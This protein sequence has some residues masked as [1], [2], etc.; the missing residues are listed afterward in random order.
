MDFLVDNYSVTDILK[1]MPDTHSEIQKLSSKYG[2]IKWIF[3]TE[4]VNKQFPEKL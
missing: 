2:D 1:E 3:Y 4:Q